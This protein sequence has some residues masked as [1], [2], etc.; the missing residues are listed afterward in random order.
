[1][2]TVVPGGQADETQ[3]RA[4]NPYSLYAMKLVP[5]WPGST[6]FIVGAP[7]EAD[8]NAV[9]TVA[10]GLTNDSDMVPARLMLAGGLP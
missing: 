8:S 7:T 2:P 5:T 3:A 6:R 10:A 9:L 4:A 1:M